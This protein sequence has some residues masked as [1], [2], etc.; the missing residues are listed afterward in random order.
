MASPTSIHL[1]TEKHLFE[2]NEKYE[3]QKNTKEKKF[4]VWLSSMFVFMCEQV[5]TKI[6]SHINSYSQCH[7]CPYQSYRQ[8]DKTLLRKGMYKKNS[9]RNFGI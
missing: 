8:V 9:D 3:L 1:K 5:V 4:N 6:V 2:I 7:S